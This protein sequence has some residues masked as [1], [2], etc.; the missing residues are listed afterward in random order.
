MPKISFGLTLVDSISVKLGRMLGTKDNWSFMV[1]GDNHTE[2]RRE[3]EV[4]K[5]QNFWKINY[6]FR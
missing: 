5:Y 6:R 3:L 2:E 1:F 4:S